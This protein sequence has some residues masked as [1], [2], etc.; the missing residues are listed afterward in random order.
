MHKFI[1]FLGTIVFLSV[2]ACDSINDSPKSAIAEDEQEINSVLQEDDLVFDEMDEGSE[3]TFGDMDP[4]WDVPLPKTTS[5]HPADPRP[6]FGRIITERKRDVQVIFDSDTTAQAHVSV[7]FI[8]KFI[9]KIPQWSGD[10]LSWQ[11]FEKPLEHDVKRIANLA[12][13]TD[14]RRDTSRVNPRRRYRWHVTSVSLSEG[15]SSVATV[16]IVE[17]VV[18]AEGMD[19][20]VITNPLEYFIN[21]RTIVNA[22]ISSKVKVQ[23]KVENLTTN[24]VEFPEG[25]GAFENLRLHYGLNRLGNHARKSFEF[26]GMDDNGYQ[27]YEGT[28]TI[29]QRP[30]IHHSIIDLIDNG[31]I[32]SPDKDA[33]PY[34]SASWA[35]PYA[36][37]W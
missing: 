14:Q 4:N 21:R 22:H 19:D 29:R 28:W 16:D 24:P 11:R 18:K 8:G 13:Y 3:S 35:M 2:V 12:K 26:V 33:Y 36:V 7:K 31:T 15:H 32:L 10:T 30:G 17:L 25:S 23:V 6:R 37:S 34:S 1:L 20:I 27:I 9:S 5:D